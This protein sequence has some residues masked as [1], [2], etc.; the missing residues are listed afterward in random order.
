MYLSSLYKIQV[1]AHLAF[2]PI[3]I[4]PTGYTLIERNKISS[5]NHRWLWSVTHSG[6]APII[7]EPLRGV[8]LSKVVATSKPPRSLFCMDILAARLS[9]GKMLTSRLAMAYL[10]YGAMRNYSER[11]MKS[12]Y[13]VIMPGRKQISVF[14]YPHPVDTFKYRRVF[15]IWVGLMFR[16]TFPICR[17]SPQNKKASWLFSLR[18]PY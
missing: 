17:C 11:P 18:T 12:S 2:L 14:L 13:S 1:S 7:M 15:S 10:R 16:K 5:W 9:H 8:S 6:L 3:T 4:Y